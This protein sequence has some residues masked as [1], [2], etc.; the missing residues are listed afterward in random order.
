MGLLKRIWNWI[1]GPEDNLTFEKS[2]NTDI[3]KLNAKLVKFKAEGLV[4][5]IRNSRNGKRIIFDI[6]CC[7]CKKKSNTS[8]VETAKR[9]YLCQKC[10]DKRTGRIK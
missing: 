4:A 7:K 1:L 2:L 8:N 3:K 10:S 5:W 6:R 9:K